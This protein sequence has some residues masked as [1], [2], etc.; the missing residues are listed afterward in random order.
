ME[1]RRKQNTDQMVTDAIEREKDNAEKEVVL[2]MDSDANLCTDSSS[3]E[4]ENADE[5]N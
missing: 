2:A 1:E 4:L 3:D 5:E